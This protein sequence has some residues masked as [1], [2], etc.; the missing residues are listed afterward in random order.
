[1]LYFPDWRKTNRNKFMGR[2]K[3]D[4]KRKDFDTSCGHYSLNKKQAWDQIPLVNSKSLRDVY[5]EGLEKLGYDKMI[6]VRSKDKEQK[7]EF[8][9]YSRA[10]V[11]NSTLHISQSVRTK[12]VDDLRS[13]KPKHDSFSVNKHLKYYK[14]NLVSSKNVDKIIPFKHSQK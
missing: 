3:K 10:N 13:G 1:M 2:I 6:R 8:L 4:G 5:T 11:W 14:K 7:H 12:L 9:P